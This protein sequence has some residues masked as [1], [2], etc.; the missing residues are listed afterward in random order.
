[1]GALMA[2]QVPTSLRPSQIPAQGPGVDAMADPTCG[3]RV[4]PATRRYV[5]ASSLDALRP[6]CWS[7]SRT[8][9]RDIFS[10]RVA[11]A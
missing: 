10:Q 5:S 8:V 7:F 2:Q 11:R 1:M 3:I 6:K 4:F 9:W